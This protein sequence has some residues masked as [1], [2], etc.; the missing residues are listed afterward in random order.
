[1]DKQGRLK[2]RTVGDSS[3]ESIRHRQRLV[4]MPQGNGDQATA[5]TTRQ[6]RLINLH[7]AKYE[8]ATNW[9]P[10]LVNQVNNH[11]ELREF[12]IDTNLQ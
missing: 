9:V 12:I 3:C 7:P 6:P 11:H 5:T 4:V 1:M 2:F 8:I 10:P